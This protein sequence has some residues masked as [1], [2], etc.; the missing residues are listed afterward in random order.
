MARRY[1]YEKEIS[2]TGLN[3]TRILKA[4]S[5]RELELK[6]LEVQAQWEEQWNKK[7]DAERQRK[8]REKIKEDHEKSMAY[9]DKLT[10]DAEK[11][12]EKMNNILVD[13]LSFK[14]F[15][16]LKLKD[17][18][19]FTKSKPKEP[20]I[21]VI[22]QAPKI[23]QAKYNQNPPLLSIFSKRSADEHSQKMT[24]LFNS[25]FYEWED[26]K[27]AISKDNEN[28]LDQYNKEIN[29]WEK[30][31]QAYEKLLE[32]KNSSVEQ[33]HLIYSSGKNSDELEFIDI[34]CEVYE[35][36]INSVSYPFE[37]EQVVELEYS[38][39]N[40]LL[41]LDIYL[42]TIED[43]P[44]LK[45]VTYVKTKKE[46]NEQFH[47]EA[48]IKK[49][50][51]DVIYQMVLQILNMIFKQ[52]EGTNYIET[53]VLNGKVNTIDRSTGKSIEP[54]IVSLQVSKESFIELNLKAID[55]KA[56]FKSA[57]GIS[58]S[59][60]SNITPIAPVLQLNKLD[61]RFVDEYSVA[62]DI[63]ETT[64]LAA[65]DWQDFENL[66][67]ELFEKEFSSNGGE[68]KITQASRD[69]GVDAVAFDPDPIRGGKIVIQAKRY[70]NV[71]GVSAVRDLYGT[72]MNEGATKGILV[73]TSN[74]GSDAYDFAKGKPITLLNG[75][76]LLSLL[77]KHGHRAKIDIQEAKEIFKN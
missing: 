48:Y 12:Q 65:M 35:H 52:D 69:G 3:K 66:I 50:Y 63:D 59:K 26:T 25:D 51:D 40:K 57:K 8:E 62:G 39:D 17:E 28:K 77:E 29:A 5:Q 64:N 10:Q 74:Y 13:S 18:R 44:N 36:I 23:T 60:L 75:A 9:A 1:Y 58:A 32:E 14:P 22:P 38:E 54:Y 24:N 42:P 46:F 20:E 34:L 31:K 15:N 68:V 73:T 53:V 16:W 56:W 47:T 43:I 2:H 11:I 41:L 21:S 55:P 67:R 71:V 30:E 4:N 70:T 49:L 37:F 61:S 45:K 19:V 7:C 33:K 27:D 72:T 76:N 6:I